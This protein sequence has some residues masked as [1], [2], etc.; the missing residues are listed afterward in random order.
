MCGIA[1]KVSSSRPLDPA[2]V[3]RMRDALIHRGPDSAGTYS[4]A[5]IC[6]GVRRLAI[7]DV[8]HG[9]QPLFNERRNVAVILN[10]EIYN[11]RE[12][13]QQLE[14]RGHRFRTNSDAEVVVHLYE[15]EGI[16]LV[17]RL[18]GMFAFAL[19]DEDERKLVLARDRVGKKPLYYWERDGAL[20]FASE[21]AALLQDPSIPREP[22]YRALDIYLSLLYVPHPM[23][24]I[25]GVRKLPPASILTWRAGRSEIRNYWQLHYE[26]KNAVPRAEAAELVRGHL[27]E[28]VKLRLIS[29]RP[30]GAFLSGGVDSAAVVAAMAET[31]SGALKTFSIGF[32]TDRFNE[33]PHARAVAERFGADHTELVVEADAISVLPKLITHYGDPFGDS[34]AIPSFYVAQLAAKDVVVALNG[35]GGDESFAGYNRYVSNAVAERLNSVPFPLRRGLARIAAATPLPRVPNS[36]A[37]RIRRFGNSLGLS[38]GERYAMRMSYLALPARDQLYDGAFAA[39]VRDASPRQVIVDAWN[40]SSAPSAV[41]R[42]LDVDVRTYL[43]GDL[44]VKMDVATMA[45]SLEAR[46]PFLDH[47]FMEMAAQLPSELK[48]R[49]LVTKAALKDAVR[50]IVPDQILDRPKWG[51][52]VPMADWMR[53]PLRPYTRDVLLDRRTIDRGYFRPKAVEKILNSVDQGYDRS[54]EVWLLLVLELWHRR[55]IDGVPESALL[56]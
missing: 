15:D 51:F 33:L 52:S 11:Y 3:R 8:D 20:S 6:L 47:V 29:E 4:S 44:L 55:F 37:A 17:H 2:V 48:V 22:D 40:A 54:S 28:A 19:W 10:G 23:S 43:P 9:D 25:K 16:D 36:T 46:S 53:G 45:N 18:R 49:G 50:G 30:L 1:G 42:M 38:P 21:L 24:A 7:I 12:L 13:K 34:S 27:H 41:D 39:E 35:D 5:S 32:T 26:P 56:S 14:A 31:V